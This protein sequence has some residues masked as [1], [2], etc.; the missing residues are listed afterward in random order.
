MTSTPAASR[1][2]AV[3]G[4]SPMPPATFSPLAV[5]KSMPRVSRSPGSSCSTAWRPGLPIRASAPTSRTPLLRVL[6]GARLADDRDLD[7]ARIGHL[8]L[9][10]LDHVAGEPR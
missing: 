9:D 5:T 8:L 1:A 7:L 4:V 6:H 10:L 3:D 2:S